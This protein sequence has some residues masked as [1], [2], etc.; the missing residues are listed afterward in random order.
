MLKDTLPTTQLKQDCAISSTEEQSKNYA[1]KFPIKFIRLPY[2][3]LSFTLKI[4]S[5]GLFDKAIASWV[6]S[7]LRR[8]GEN[9]LKTKKINFVDRVYG[10]LQTGRMTEDYL[11]ALI[12]QIRSN[13][14]EIYAHPGASELELEALLSKKV[15]EVLVEAGF[16]LTNYNNLV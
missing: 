4:D 8:Y 9:L 15:K 2:E 3:E 1:P 16:E 5:R 6:F 13:L 10:L 12:L 11:V 7:S 14:V